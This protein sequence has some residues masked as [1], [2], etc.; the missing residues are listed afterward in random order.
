MATKKTAPK[1]PLKPSKRPKPKPA[2]GGGP[3][4][5]R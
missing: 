3:G 2:D 5:P 4:E 1:K